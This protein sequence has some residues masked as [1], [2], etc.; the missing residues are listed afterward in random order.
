[1]LTAPNLIDGYC[2]DHERL[3]HRL[4]TVYIPAFLVVIQIF[5]SPKASVYQRQVRLKAFIEQYDA[6]AKEHG[7]QQ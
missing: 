1:M 2:H 6:L 5:L 3:Q 7:L 4:H